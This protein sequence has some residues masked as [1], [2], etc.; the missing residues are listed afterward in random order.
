MEI[1]LYVILSELE[2]N[3]VGCLI[4]CPKA[5]ELTAPSRLFIRARYGTI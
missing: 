5:L 3:Q 4:L 2:A 1:E